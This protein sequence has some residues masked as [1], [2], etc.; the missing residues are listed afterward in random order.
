M[1]VD[2]AEDHYC[3]QPVLRLEGM[4]GDLD[5]VGVVQHSDVGAAH[6]PE[7]LPAAGRV[8]D[9][10]SEL[11][12]AD[13]GWHGSQRDDEFLRVTDERARRRRS[14]EPFRRVRY[15][16]GEEHPRGRRT[17]VGEDDDAVQLDGSHAGPVAPA[18]ADAYL[19]DTGRLVRQQHVAAPGQGDGHEAP[20]E[21]SI[22]GSARRGPD[23]SGAKRGISREAD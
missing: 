4:A 5:A 14:A 23:R 22:V 6:R 11:Q 2:L 8:K 3:L 12:P 17:L 15:L 9:R 21:V 18:E 20:S 13:L 19:L 1:A 7:R 16:M 10:R